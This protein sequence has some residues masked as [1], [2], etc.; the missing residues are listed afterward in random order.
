M[1]ITTLGALKKCALYILHLQHNAFYKTETKKR[2]KI[3]VMHAVNITALL[4]TAP[5][6]GKVLYTIYN[7]MR[8][9]S[10]L[11]H[12]WI[13][14]RNCNLVYWPESMQPRQG[15]RWWQEVEL[16]PQ[17]SS[18]LSCLS[19]VFHHHHHHHIMVHKTKGTPANCHVWPF[20][21]YGL[22][23]ILTTSLEFTN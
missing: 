17:T 4:F 20:F 9:C 1:N 21:L 16:L 6:I 11:L 19:S 18:S 5:N 23:I 14:G 12:C 3:A 15:T 8:W 22:I 2:L 10:G 7:W 13:W